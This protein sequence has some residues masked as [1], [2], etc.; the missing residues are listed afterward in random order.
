MLLVYNVFVL[1]E[2]VLIG[3]SSGHLAGQF[4]LGGGIFT[5]PLLRLWLGW[6][7]LFLIVTTLLP[8]ISSTLLAPFD[9]YRAVF[10]RF[11]K[12]KRL[13]FFVFFKVLV[14]AGLGKL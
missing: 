1:L 14:G 3:F 9:F 11:F 13:A 4:G 7:S 6:S 2:A 10:Q 12:V 8:V 5:T